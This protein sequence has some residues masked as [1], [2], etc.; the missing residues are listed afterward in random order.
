MRGAS[1]LGWAAIAITSAI[2]VAVAFDRAMNFVY[3]PMF[4]AV[5]VECL[6]LALALVARPERSIP[7]L[8]DP[9]V[10]FVLFQSQFF[11]VGPVALPFTMAF[12]RAAI[13]P[14]LALITVVAF[15]G[16]LIA[17][18]IGYH[19]PLGSLIASR[20]P[21]FSRQ[22]GK[23]RSIRVERWLLVFCLACCAVYIVYQGG[24]IK[25][26]H[27]GYGTGESAAI[28]QA[29]FLLLLMTTLLIAWRVLSLP[30]P[31]WRDARLLLVVIAFEV[32]FWGILLGQRKWLFQ[33][34]F[35]LTAMFLLRRGRR[36]M[37]RYVLPMI[38]VMLVF[39]LSVWGSIRGR[40][41]AMLASDQTSQARYGDLR[42]LHSGY[43]ESVSDPFNTACLVL[44]VFPEREP[45][46]YGQTLLV[47]LLSPIPRAVW[48][49]KPIGL[50]KELTWYL[51]AYYAANYD[52]T[53][54]LSITPT[55]VGDFYANL[56]IAGILLGGLAFGV[57]FRVM[58]AYAV[59]DMVD[60]LQ[61]EPARVLIASVFLA[62]LVELR[63][64]T[65]QMV[66]FYMYT[67]LPLLFVL[68]FFS[69]QPPATARHP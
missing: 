9:V 46:R 60:G 36:A 5:A 63:A 21:D 30:S 45:Y 49:T 4:L 48:P 19:A 27:R 23:F 61:L 39:Y 10:L 17:F 26:L 47:A 68:K 16:L 56:G 24:I 7:F 37:P 15:I 18:L 50:G 52:P 34:F 65:A 40:P 25:M 13:P 29:P 32:L 41:L 58:A 66:L 28:F 57:G 51:G 43:L 53:R 14:S 35:G 2:G 6:I 22:A 11:V 54:G 1:V 59:K 69:F 67:M 12:S 31:R 62:G 64:E 38:L 44:Q 42:G 20:L 55:L 33:L 8:C 3:V